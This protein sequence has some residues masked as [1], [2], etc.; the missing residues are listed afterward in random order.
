MS[1]CTSVYVAEIC[2]QHL[3]C[4]MLS[5]FVI[6]YAAGTCVAYVLTG[7][8][9]WKLSAIIFLTISLLGSVCTFFI[10]ESPYWLL[11]KG[12]NESAKSTLRKLRDDDELAIEAECQD[13]LYSLTNN[14][15]KKEQQ[16]WLKTFLKHWKPFAILIIFQMC[17]QGSGYNILLTYSTKLFPKFTRTIDTKSLAVGYSCMILL[18]ALLSPFVIQFCNRRS[19]MKISSGGMTFGLSLL[20][21]YMLCDR[22]HSGSL[23]LA[24]WMVPVS[25]YIYAFACI[26]GAVTISESMAGELFPTEV[27]GIMCGTLQA[28]GTTIAALLV[29]M[30]PIVES[31]ISTTAIVASF[32]CFSFFMMLFSIFILPET[33]GKNLEQIQAEL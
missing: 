15:K 16:R 33:R 5:L 8:L 2:E 14:R 12:R 9:S 17:L 32:T 27:R 1:L 20:V 28:C 11:K 26:A 7:F 6:L 25:L 18:S 21:V 31:Y 3:R 22:L 29:K 13:I 24:E 4:T 30:Y 19:V 10:L 23:A